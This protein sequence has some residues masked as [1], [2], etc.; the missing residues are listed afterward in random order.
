MDKKLKGFF[1]TATQIVHEAKAVADTQAQREAA[2]KETQN[3][4]KR[5]LIAQIDTELRPIL[6]VLRS[7]PSKGGSTFAVSMNDMSWAST[8]ARYNLEV[9]YCNPGAT[10][11]AM[12]FD[13]AEDQWE[14]KVEL[15]ISRSERGGLEIHSTQYSI[16]KYDGHHTRYTCAKCGDFEGARRELARG[17]GNF[18]AGRIAEIGEKLGATQDDQSTADAINVFS[19]PLQLK[20]AP[21]QTS[22][23]KKHFWRLW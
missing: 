12:D 18:A 14:P 9:S 15:T 6:D 16:L 2:R 23:K 4:N 19:K 17:L 3:E 21:A 13:S 22:A 8:D 11:D 20:T 5:L 7:L 1:E 10:R